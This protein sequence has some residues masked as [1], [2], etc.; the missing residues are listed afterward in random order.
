MVNACQQP[1]RTW[2]TTFPTVLEIG[3]AST[4]FQLQANLKDK[5]F[6]NDLY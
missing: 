3:T 2:A 4:S 1:E 6:E 5:V